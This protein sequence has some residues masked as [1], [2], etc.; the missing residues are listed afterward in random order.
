MDNTRDKNGVLF[1][2]AV[3]DQKFAII[4]DSGIN[5]TVPPNFW[6]DTK[7]VLESHFKRKEFKNGLIAAILK[8]GQELKAHFPWNPGDKNE[9]GNEISKG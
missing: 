4:G 1:Y 6:E 8:A 3:K 2:V 9:L 5:K 7:A